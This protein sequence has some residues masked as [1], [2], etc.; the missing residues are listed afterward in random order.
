MIKILSQIKWF[1]GLVLLQAL[2]LNQM[3]IEGYAT[4]FPYIYFILKFH[5]RASRNELLLWA[6]FMGLVMDMFSNTAGMNAASFTCLAFFRTPFLRM[7]TSRDLEEDFQPSIKVMGIAPFL[8]YALMLSLFF[9][10]LFIVLDTF[11]F[12][13]WSVMIFRIVT[14]TFTTLLC[15]I[16]FEYMWRKK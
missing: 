6:F 5:S 1:I 15:I 13:N 9:C 10:I 3:H 16:G 12:F 4:P 14:S 8:R 11:S 7:M 2:I